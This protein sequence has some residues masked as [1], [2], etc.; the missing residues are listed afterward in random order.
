ML[1]NYLR[2]GMSAREMLV[3]LL[4]TIPIILISLTVHEVAHGYVS[5]KLGDPTARN[6]GRLSLNPLKHLD[7]LGALSMLLFGIGWAKPVPVNARYYKKPKQGMAL[8][9]LAGPCANLLLAFIG[10]VVFVIL[11]HCNLFSH[12]IEIGDTIY[13]D[14]DY[15]WQLVLYGFVQNFIMLNAYLAVFNLLPVPPFDGS[16]IAFV[17]LPDRF[18]FAVMKYERIIMLVVLLLICTCVLTLPFGYL[19]DLLISGM[20]ALV[21]AVWNA[22][23]ALFAMF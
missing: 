3:M 8:T 20:T 23:A 15:V 9:A 11:G 14:P 5:Y 2:S 12:V 7:P 1:L 18:Y 22:I 4:M 19:S 6:L 16:R 10:V 21:N 17:F 13:Y